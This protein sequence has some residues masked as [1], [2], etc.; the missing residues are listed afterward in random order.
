MVF[1]P[2]RVAAANGVSTGKRYDLLVIEPHAVENLFGWRVRLGLNTE[3]EVKTHVPEVGRTLGCIRKSPI[4]CGI[5][6]KPI[7]TSRP[8]G[9]L[10]STH[11]LDRTNSSKCPQITIGNP[12]KL[13]LDL[14]HEFTAYVKTCIGA[15]QCLGL[16]AHSSV[17]ANDKNNKHD[18]YWEVDETCLPPVLD[19]LS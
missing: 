15:V 5:L 9:N 11:L 16:E 13:L 6:G 18:Y 4:R 8:P 12:V 7:D 1:S 19:T 2:V 3:T 14:S 10:G 17:V